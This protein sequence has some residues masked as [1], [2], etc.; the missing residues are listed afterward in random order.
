[1]QP[2]TKTTE[3]EGEAT[4]QLAFAQVD[5]PH[6]SFDFQFLVPALRMMLDSGFRVALSQDPVSRRGSVLL[7]KI[8]KTTVLYTLVDGKVVY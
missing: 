7:G 3:R 1:M 4:T 2:E 8:H 5:G 6:L